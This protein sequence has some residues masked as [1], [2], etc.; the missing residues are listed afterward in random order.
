MK[1]AFLGN[2]HLACIKDAWEQRLAKSSDLEISA[3]FV[4]GS[5]FSFF[6]S[7]QPIDGG[8]GLKDNLKKK[9]A[10]KIWRLTHGSDEPFYANQFDMVVV[11][12]LTAAPKLWSLNTPLSAGESKLQDKFGK[13]PVSKAVWQQAVA[14]HCQFELARSIKRMMNLDEGKRVIFIPR[15]FLRSDSHEFDPLRKA[16]VEWEQLS[17]EEKSFIQEREYSMLPSVAESYGIEAWLPLPAM[18]ENGY[19][20]PTKFSKGALGSINPKKGV[21]KSYGDSPLD[22]RMNYSHKNLEYG[23]LWVDAILKNL[24]T[25]EKIKPSRLQKLKKYFARG[26]Q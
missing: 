22:N 5:G 6:N 16:P 13:P 25:V 12:G 11:V 4:C 3:H 10:P 24:P 8:I 23:Q 20:C 26:T 1:I 17:E 21:S 9:S 15:P 19:R 2:S 18:V 7:L 14:G